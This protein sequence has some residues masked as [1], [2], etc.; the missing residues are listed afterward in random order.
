M[1]FSN[2]SVLP[3]L[4]KVKD[5][6]NGSTENMSLS[7]IEDKELRKKLRN[8]QSALAARERKKARMLEL[9]KQ[10]ATLQESKKQLQDEN[11]ALRMRVEILSEKCHEAGLSCD[12][13]K[14]PLF[15]AHC[16]TQ[17]LSKYPANGFFSNNVDS[18]SENDPESFVH[19]NYL[20]MQDT[21][22]QNQLLRFQKPQQN[23]AGYNS[24]SMKYKS[25]LDDKKCKDEIEPVSKMSPNPVD[26]SQTN[27]KN[28]PHLYPYSTQVDFQMKQPNMIKQEDFNHALDQTENFSTRFDA[29]P[30]FVT[31]QIGEKQNWPSSC[32]KSEFE[33]ISLFQ[34]PSIGALWETGTKLARRETKSLSQSDLPVEDQFSFS[35]EQTFQPNSGQNFIG[36]E[37]S[38][39]FRKLKSFHSVDEGSVLRKSGWPNRNTQSCF[40]QSNA[41]N[42]LGLDRVNQKFSAAECGDFPNGISDFNFLPESFDEVT[43]QTDFATFKDETNELMSSKSDSG[44][45]MDDY[46]Y[47]VGDSSS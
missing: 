43:D 10:V 32:E 7:S 39:Q 16:P 30:G 15:R 17:M 41:N 26:S 31:D 11:Q 38:S 20:E 27:M 47:W 5:T 45:S 35:S 13:E 34:L 3:V 36:E 42:G 28:F 18:L 6:Q 46:P 23:I 24:Y 29:A 22:F 14:S 12:H 19:Q 40:Y 21:F 4:P 8:R 37:I 9:E 44:V 25:Y 1:P 33:N 2:K